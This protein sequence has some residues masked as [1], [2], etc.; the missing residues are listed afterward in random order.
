MNLRKLFG[1]SRK[2]LWK[3]LAAELDARHVDGGTW[4]DDE[5]RVEHGGW[6]VTLDTVT[7]MVGKVPVTY[8]RF[9]A[10]YVN[11]EGFR[12]TAY[13]R[14]F[15]SDIA[16]WFGMQDIVVGHATFDRDFILKGN[17]ERRLKALFD[18]AEVRRLLERQEGVRLFVRDHEGWF[19]PKYPPATDLLECTLQ[20]VVLDKVRLED[21]FALLG[22]V[23]DR[24]LGTGSATDADP[25]VE[26]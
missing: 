8:T 1:P 6:T 13:R 5:I 23:L 15:V 22:A 3:R 21:G 17:D 9:R 24:L 14:S 2:E 25:G 7:V 19:A 20:G 16:K 12:F 10:P 18:D 11:P 26:L 4:K